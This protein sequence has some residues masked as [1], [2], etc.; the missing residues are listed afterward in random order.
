MS[1]VRNLVLFLTACAV[2]SSQ[3]FTSGLSGVITDPNGA[4][5][6]NAAVSVKN[7]ATGDARAVKA[8]EDG[9]YTFSQLAPGVYELTAEAS[10]FRKLVAPSLTLQA[11]Q[12]SEFNLNMAVGDVTQSIEVS[13]EAPGID[14]QTANKS[15][16]L[17]TRQVLDLPVNARDPLVLVH[18]TAGVTGVRTGV[19]T[20]TTDQ[21]HNRFALNGGRDESSA[22]LIDGVPATAVDWGG[23]LAMPSVDAVQE[24]QVMRNTFDA[25]YGKTDGGVVSMVTKGGGNSFHGSAFEFLRNNHLDANSWTNNRSGVARTIFQRNQFGGSLGGP[26]WKSKRL[27]FYGAYEGLR[28]GSPSVNVSSVPTALERAGDFSQTR[29]SNGALSVIYDPATTRANP[30]GAGFI[31]DPFPGNVIPSTRFD[32]VGVKAVGLYPLPSSA[33]DLY[34]A[35]RNFALGGKGVSNNERMDVRVDWAKSERYSFFARVTKAWQQDIVP[36]FF[37]NGADSNFGG[38][39]PR[40]Q[41]VVGNTFVPTSTWVIN[42]LVGAGRWREVQVSPSQG[43]NATQIGFPASLVNQF[44][45]L[46]LPQFNV[47]NYAQLNNPRYLDDPRMTNNLQINNT[48]EFHNHSVK[49]GFIIEAGQINPTD[50][51][52][53]TFSFS[54]GMTSGPNATVDSTTT[55]NAVASLLLGTGA[56]GSAPTN[57]RLALTQLY[58]AGYVQDTWRIN[59]KL[60]LNVGLRYEIQMPRTERYDRFNYFDFNATN[61]LSQQTG[62]NLKGGLAYDS[63]KQRGLWDTD[64]KNFAPRIGI[65]YKITDKLVVRTGYGIYYPPTVAVSNG[66]T[67]GF[68]TTTAWTSSQGGGG[69]V[70]ANLLSNPFPQGLNQPVGSSQGLATL[71]GNSINAFQRLHPSAYVQSYSIDFQYEVSKSAFIEVG[72]SGTQGRKLLLGSSPNL[73]QLDPKYLSL[74]TALNDQ[75]P[76]PFFGIIPSGNLAGATIPRYQLLRPYPQ[77]S[78]VTLSGD[79]PGAGSS[80][81]ALNL[82]YNQRL[83]TGLSA[84]VTFQW[85]KAI[86]NSS[87]TQAWEISDVLR[88]TYDRASD[89][90]ISGHDLPRSLVAALV[91][92]L[93]VGKGKAFGGSMNKI[94]DAVA[95]GWQVSTITRFASGLPL[96]FSATN[97]L[98][99]YGFNVL[100]PNITN[101]KDLNVS[102][103]G[104]DQWFNTSSSVVSAPAPF[105]MGNAPRW[106]PNIR[107]GAMQQADVSLQKNFHIFEFMKAQFR[108]EAFNIANSVQFGRASTTVGAS[109]FGRVTGYAPG[110]G[111]RNIQLALRLDF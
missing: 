9:R 76:N 91:Y 64:S 30:N 25:Q 88:N 48:K 56:S 92:E 63:S 87:E 20:A 10:G 99:V 24:V 39:N 89:R 31:R 4:A 66:T 35:A 43:R 14:T 58:Y 97:S 34:T 80:F 79:T 28:Q 42:V 2:C 37:G 8:G 103:Q 94:A 19:S 46:T 55:G 29:N 100:R 81:N 102:N 40:H 70:P 12:V 22:I 47:S 109:D 85:S 74:G 73:N 49:F 62:L 105:T 17:N 51:N 84:L 33:G 18:A 41:V 106:L 61:P 16:T 36:T 13:A 27:F 52:S 77:F 68:S 7:K 72:Y 111:P 6:P 59:R 75:V 21:N 50:V 110:A 54:R 1:S 96:Q 107:Y 67:D 53:P 98:S 38:M 65:A 101:L 44:S 23:A 26:I 5:I 11:S 45:A 83:S 82:K 86:D 78:S 57:V 108:A 93:P 95:G 71:V 104:P 3:I 69:I 90:S 15:V 32:A 60:T